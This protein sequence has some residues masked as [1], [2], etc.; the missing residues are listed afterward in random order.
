MG[1]AATGC[2]VFDQ[3][4]DD[5]HRAG[6]WVSL[7]GEM[8]GDLDAVPLLL[9]MGLDEFSVNPVAIPKVKALIR[10]LA[11][12]DMQGL[13]ERALRLPTAAAIRALVRETVVNK[14]LFERE[15]GGD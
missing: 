3:A 9:A 2:L 8:A 15:H 1:S 12:H 5:A 6:K 4:I 13:V 14:R 7:C 11:F 10:S